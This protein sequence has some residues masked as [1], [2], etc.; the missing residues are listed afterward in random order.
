MEIGCVGVRAYGRPSHVWSRLRFVGL[1]RHSLRTLIETFF[2]LASQHHKT[3][4]LPDELLEQLKSQL[5]CRE[6]Q[7]Q[8]LAALYN[9]CVLILMRNHPDSR[10]ENTSLST[11]PRRAWPILHGQIHF[12]KVLSVALKTATRGYQ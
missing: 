6:T 12:D 8:Q 11:L 1:A 10:I 2:E 5:P 7:I 3:T 4:M 9:V